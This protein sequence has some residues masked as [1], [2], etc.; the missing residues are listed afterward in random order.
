M[1][2]QNVL[3]ETPDVSLFALVVVASLLDG[4]VGNRPSISSFFYRNFLAVPSVTRRTTEIN[5]VSKSNE[6]SQSK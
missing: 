2:V 3:D 1:G 4:R 6:A 5:F